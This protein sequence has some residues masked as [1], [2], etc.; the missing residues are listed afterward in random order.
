[1]EI[2]IRK[3][4]LTKSLFEQLP[5]SSMARLTA[6]SEVYGFVRHK[7]CCYAL[8]KANELFKV[9][10]FNEVSLKGCSVYTGRGIALR[11]NSTEEAE[12]WFELYSKLKEE[13]IN[14]GQVF[15]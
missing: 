5:S 1:M 3:V 13:A 15:L 12:H 2:E 11:F 14:A 9:V 8:A 10:L 7:N 6:V 4:K